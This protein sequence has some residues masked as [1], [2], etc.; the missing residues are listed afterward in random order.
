MTDVAAKHKKMKS[1][2]TQIKT[3]INMATKKQPLNC[4]EDIRQLIV[5][6]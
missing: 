3:G 6:Y 2:K 4:K 1:R 5:S